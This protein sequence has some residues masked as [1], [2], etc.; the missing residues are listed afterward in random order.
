MLHEG[1]KGYRQVARDY[2]K[3]ED[4]V[5]EA[6]ENTPGLKLLAPPDACCVPIASEDES[7]LPIY[8]VASVLESKGWNPFTGQNPP[9]MTVCIGEQHLR[10]VDELVSDLKEATAMVR[11]NP[12]MKLEGSTAVYGAAAA[13]PDELLDSVLRSYIDTCLRVKRKE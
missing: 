6:V 12:S 3:V 7:K 9:V 4:K 11:A 13:L 1:A 5:C 10:V 2:R 8:A